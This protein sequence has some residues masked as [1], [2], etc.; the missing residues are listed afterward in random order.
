[1]SK[2]LVLKMIKLLE[3]DGINAKQQVLMLLK[4][5]KEQK[6]GTYE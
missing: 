4:R 5:Y 2:D 6:E 1:M 3:T